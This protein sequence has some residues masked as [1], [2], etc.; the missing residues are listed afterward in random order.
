MRIGTDSRV[1]SRMAATFLVGA[2][3]PLLLS[4]G[5]MAQDVGLTEERGAMTPASAEPDLN[6]SQQAYMKLLS[7]QRLQKQAEKYESK[8]TAA[9]SESKREK[10]LAKAKT[11]FEGAIRDYVT[12]LRLDNT[13]YE[14]YVGLGVLFA[15]AGQHEQSLESFKQAL[16]LDPANVDALLGS[17]RAQIASFKVEDAKATYGELGNLDEASAGVLLAEMRVWLDAQKSRLGPDA[18]VEVGDAINDFDRWIS[19]NEGS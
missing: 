11:A 14:A 6:T 12:A 7:G 5:L 4:V 19:D 16:E 8:A 10:L 15:K 2:L 17:A 1:C 13:Q 3:L 18:A 9:N